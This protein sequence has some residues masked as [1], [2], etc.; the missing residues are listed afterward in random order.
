MKLFS[1]NVNGL[2][3]AHGK[4][5]LDWLTAAQPDVLCVQ[6]TKCHPDQLEDALRAPAGYHTYW[7][8]AEKKGYSGVALYSKTEPLSVQIGLDI[9]DY[10]REGRTIVADYGDFVFIG[11]YFP[12]GSRDHSR[13]PYK[14]AYKADF[15][16]FCNDLRA[17]GKA[18]V[19]CGDVN[20]SHQEIDLARPRQNQTTTGFLPEERA[21][22]DDVVAQGYVDTFRAL[23][24]ERAGAYSWWSYIGGARGRNVGWRLDYFFV[25]PELWPRVDGA[26]IHPDVMGS[27]H[28]PVSLSLKEER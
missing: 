6:E 7:A 22:I 15:L 8:W 26:A 20:T 28:C 16:A 11:A 25:S 5:F 3:A 18:V 23:Y 27:D 17:Q 9:P 12:N 10:D 21:W 4:G 1:W 14:M 24:P 13:V 19:F 2:R